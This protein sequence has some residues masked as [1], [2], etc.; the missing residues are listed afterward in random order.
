MAGGRYGNAEA[1]TFNFGP[2]AQAALQQAQV[3]R[4][5]NAQLDRQLAVDAAKLTPK[6]IRPQEIGKYMESYNDLKAFSIRNRDALRSGR[7]PQAFAQYQ[8]KLASLQATISESV[9]AKEREKAA[10]GFYAK[11]HGKINED[12]FQS[13]LS[14]VKAPVGSPE[15]EATKGWDISQTLWNPAQFDGGKWATTFNA[16]VKPVERVTPENLPTGQVLNKKTSFRDPSAIANFVGKSYDS[17]L[18]HVQK[19]YNDQFENLADD[20][21]QELENYAGKYIPGFKVDSP[22]NLAIA[23]NLYGQVERDMGQTIGGSPYKS[24]QAFSR[25]QQNRSFAHSDAQFEKTQAAKPDKNYAVVSDV[26]KMLKAGRYNEALTPF[27]AATPGTETVVLK[28]G[29]TPAASLADL[30]RA[31]KQNGVDATT[32]SLTDKDFKDGVIVTMVPRMNPALPKEILKVKDKNG[33]MVPAYD[34]M[35][36]PVNKSNIQPR[37]QQHMN[38][39]ANLKK[40]VKDAVF[41]GIFNSSIPTTPGALNGLDDEEIDETVPDNEEEEQL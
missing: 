20:H 16:A 6:G 11:N 37:L 19:L 12:D 31:V 29:R 24:Q 15:Y 22:K 9:A 39:S 2:L 4:Y 36:T 3:K 40:P 35:A 26:D 7:D 25:E 5:E 38:Y 32:R 13:H 30:R 23:D 34:Y 28:E 10:L 18:Y 1:V 33:K 17:D 21:K 8:D 41:K 14:S 27:E